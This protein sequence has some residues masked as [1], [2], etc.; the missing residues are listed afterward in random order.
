MSR[1]L[2][3][4][5]EENIAE[6]VNEILSL[7]QRCTSWLWSW[8]NKSHRRNMDGKEKCVIL[9]RTLVHD[10]ESVMEYLKFY[11][12]ESCRFTMQLNHVFGK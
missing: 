10:A 4:E 5:M 9:L 2:T 3:F 7:L 6:I 12:S 11:V 1:N 8:V